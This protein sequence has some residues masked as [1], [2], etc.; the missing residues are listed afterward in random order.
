MKIGHSII[1]NL[2]C[3]SIL[4]SKIIKTYYQ[5]HIIGIKIFVNN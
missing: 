3:D 1:H 4:S 5:I 2:I